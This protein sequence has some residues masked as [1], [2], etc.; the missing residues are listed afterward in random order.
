[1]SV[2]VPSSRDLSS[3]TTK[4]TLPKMEEGASLAIIRGGDRTIAVAVCATRI[5][6]QRCMQGS[7][8]R[9]IVTDRAT[10]K[11]I[12][13]CLVK[14]FKK[15]GNTLDLYTDSR[16][17]VLCPSDVSRSAPVI[18]QHGKSFAIDW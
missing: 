5:R 3:R 2:N 14:V 7:R 4:V 12:K 16:G 8:L 17:V 6:I 9:F 13:G 10:G 1:M 15:Q 18:G 11:G